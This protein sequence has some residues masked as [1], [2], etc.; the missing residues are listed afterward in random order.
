MSIT[1]YSD[2]PDTASIKVGGNDRI[3]IGS[4]GKI[5][6]NIAYQPAGIGA[7]ASDVQSKLREFV[8]VKDFGA[9]G[10]GITDDTAAFSDAYNDSDNIYL[11]D[12]EYVTS[13]FHPTRSFGTGTVKSSNADYAD[14]GERPHS[15][16]FPSLDGDFSRVNTY[17]NFERAS[18]NTIIVN[19]DSGRAQV[20]GYATDAGVA[21]YTNRDHVGQYIGMYGPK[22]QLLTTAASTTY[23]TT[24]VSAP[25]ITTGANIKIGMFIDTGHS[26]KYSGK[27]TSISFAANTLTV[28]GWFQ[29]GNTSAGQ[30]PANGFSA[31]INPASKIWGQNTN[32][33]IDNN[34]TVKTAT[35]YELGLFS[36]GTHN[37]PIWGY[38]AVNLSNVGA[39]FDKAFYASGQWKVGYEATDDVNIGLFQN[40]PQTAVVNCDNLSND[41]WV[42]SVVRLNTNYRS[43]GKILDI[44]SGGVSNWSV[45]SSGRRSTQRESFTLVSDNTSLSLTNASIVAG[46]NSTN[47]TIN[48]PEGAEAGHVIEVRKFS[49][50]DIT[51]NYLGNTRATLNTTNGVYTKLVFDGVTWLRLFYA[52]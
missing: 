41:S 12:G 17:G 14:S 30:L 31:R 34:S 48:L 3:T 24:S 18:G 6:A 2:S 8:S 19:N 47:I 13:I 21:T 49:A 39:K 52:N 23:T 43:T 26:P 35:G 32:V 37:V 11:P 27:I 9:V 38:H 44:V 29:V 5:S 50:G 25:E 42:G 28:S 4:D 46:T 15:R 40:A 45:S 10:D 22:N 36:N 20:S 1:L 51:V 7:V 16:K 33:F